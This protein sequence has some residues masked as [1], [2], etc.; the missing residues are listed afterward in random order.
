MKTLLALA[1]LLPLVAQA[2]T[3]D[4][5][6]TKN[7]AARGGAEKLRAIKTARWTGKLRFEGGGG[8]V[9]ADY[10][11]LAKSPG[12]TRQSITV[13]G[14]ENIYAYDGKLGWKVE[15]GGGRRDA[16][17][18]SA[19]D[20]KGLVEDAEFTGLLLDWKARGFKLEYLGTDDVDGTDAHKLK[21]TRPNGDFHYVFL[22]PDHFLE[23]RD[24]THRWVRGAEQVSQ[25]DFGEYENVEG[26]FW[27]FQVTSG[28]KEAPA[29]NVGLV[30]KLEFNVPV[31]DAVFAIP[32][33]PKKK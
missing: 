6:V 32:E 8:V 21:V 22:D 3:V 18:L 16:E 29:S 33:A 30:E 2:V 20:A 24:E 14:F 28:P 13:Q 1:A 15:P 5:L 25:S 11:A 4:E 12:R 27:P 23:I 31:D 26:S 7:L 19:D 9:E 17:R 10:A